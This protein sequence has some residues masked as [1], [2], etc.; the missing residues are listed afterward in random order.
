M[1]KEEKKN[2][3]ELAAPTIRARDAQ[4]SPTALLTIALL[5]GVGYLAWRFWKD[6]RDKND[7]ASRASCGDTT[8]LQTT[9]VRSRHV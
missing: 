6:F 9:E 4:T 1:E 7:A 3:R 5:G 8:G 2:A